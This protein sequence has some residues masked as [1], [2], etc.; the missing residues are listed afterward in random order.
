MNI[1]SDH[2]IR[3]PVHGYIKFTDAEKNIIDTES[4]QRIRKVKQMGMSSLVYPSATHTRF[5]HSIG[6][7]Y[8]A[9]KIAESLDLCD[10]EFKTVR[11]AG[12][13]HDIGHGPFSHTSDRVSRKYGYTHEDHSCDII[14]NDLYHLIPD[15]IDIQDIK[16][17]IKSNSKI[18]IIAGDIDADRMDYLNRDAINTGLKHG[19]IDYETII[20]F[21]GTS[22]GKL[23]FDRK[24]TYSIN[25]L[26]TARLYMHNA[27]ANHHTSRLAE[28]I[29]ERVLDRYV[30]ENGVKNMMK[31]NDYTMHTTLKNS[32]DNSIRKLYQR[33][34]NRDLFKRCYTL[35]GNNM[36]KNIINKLSNIK[37]KEYEK[38]ISNIV[39]MSEENVMIVTPILPNTDTIDVNIIDNGNILELNE[40]STL[41]YNLSEE[42]Y[43][44]SRFHVYT[45]EER[46][47]EV[48]KAT[49][50]ILN[51]KIL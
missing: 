5:S 34:R 28:T 35:R 29:L 27:I 13:L 12:L 46:T 6:V 45:T 26:L 9:G 18:N 37:S 36:P 1:N 23:V 39:G 10:K 15:E 22:D 30:S 38:I 40:I 32:D 14:D 41:S 2:R 11:L 31:H 44:Q 33:V 7:M 3:D 20:E 50:E 48:M 24:A 17:Y 16:D 19:S 47:D 43:N 8:V 42:R 25:E 4:V 49:D 51:E 21:A